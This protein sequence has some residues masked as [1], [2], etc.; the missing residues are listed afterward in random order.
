MCV[1]QGEDG[2]P[3]SSWLSYVVFSL[4][5]WKLPIKLAF[6]SPCRSSWRSCMLV[7]EGGDEG[8]DG[9]MHYVDV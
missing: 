2:Q 8:A 5:Q 3:H 9:D 6:A 1:C 7:P 4:I